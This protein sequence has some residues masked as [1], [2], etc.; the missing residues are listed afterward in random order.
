M[1]RLTDEVDIHGVKMAVYR[2]TPEDARTILGLNT[3]N[4]R[5]NGPRVTRYQRDME[6]GTWMFTGDPIQVE[7][8][9][10]LAN[11]QH[12]LTA[13]VQANV[14]L[15]WL[16]VEGLP[17][18]VQG[19]IDKN[20]VRSYV[21]TL[22]ILGVPRATDVGA[23][24]NRIYRWEHSGLGARRAGS[25]QP[26]ESVLESVRERLGSDVLTEAIAAGD[27]SASQ[28]SPNRGILTAF[29]IVLNDIEGVEEDR[30]FFYDRLADGAQLDV[31]HPIYVLRK[32]FEEMNR[33]HTSLQVEERSAVA[34]LTKAWNAYRDGQSLSTLRFR[35]GGASP[36]AMPEPH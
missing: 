27:R 21:D 33:S 16:L 12:R 26:P 9:R 30:S 5:L 17:P 11:G 34:L 35:Q 7:R 28:C 19:N 20:R 1:E 32:K 3:R 10:V 8:G 29:W 4:R 31:N 25:E 22:R 23:A 13:Q 36:E 18:G 2:V 14:T 6:D 24:V 15:D